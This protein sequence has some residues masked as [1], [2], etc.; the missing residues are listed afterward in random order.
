MTVNLKDILE[1]LGWDDGFQIPIANDENKELEQELAR[2]TLRK[3]KAKALFD[4]VGGRLEALKE[5]FKYVGQENE[6]TQRLISAHK[7]QYDAVQNQY[8]LFKAEDEN[9]RMSIKKI[10]KQLSD[11]ERME[12][13]KKADL[14][15]SIAKAD[16]LKAE[17]EWDTEALKGWEE[18]L[19]KRDDDNGIL[20]KFSREDEMRYNELEARRLILQSECL[21]KRET[22]K[23]IAAESHSYEMVIDRSG[24]A[25]KQQMADRESLIHQWKDAVKMLQQRDV[26]IFRAQEQIQA[27]YEA[28]AKQ[29]VVLEEEHNFLNNQKRVNHEIELEIQSINS[30]N[31]RMRRELGELAQ[32][33]LLMNNDHD[34][35]KRRIVQSAQ[36]LE[37]ARLKGKRLAERAAEM[38]RICSKFKEERQEL[39]RKQR[40][41]DEMT[42]STKERLKKL[43]QMI[44]NEERLY[45]I[46]VSDTEKI[47]CT[48]FRTERFLKE[49]K[50]I[51]KSVEIELN[52][53]MCNCHQLRKYISSLTKDLDKI[54]EVVYD[55]DF[56]IDDIERKLCGMLEEDSQEDD[57]KKDTL[58]KQI[59]KMEE[60]LADQKEVQRVLQAQVDRLQEEMR[61]LTNYIAQ[62]KEMVLTLEN[63]C[64]NFELE[65]GNGKKQIAAAKQATQEKQVEENMMLLRIDQLENEKKKEEKH[66]FSLETLRLSLDQ[67]IQERQIE[68]DTK[69]TVML[70]KRRNLDEERG[71]LR[72]DVALVRVKIEHIKK[73]YHV[74]CGNLGRDEDGNPLTVAHFRIRNAQEKFMLQQQGDDLDKKIRTA[75][76]EIT[77]LENTLK[78]VNLTN[79]S[80]RNSLASIKE[81]DEKTIEMKELEETHRVLNQHVKTVRRQVE[82]KIGKLKDTQNRLLAVQKATEERQNSVTQLEEEIEMVRRQEFE[83]TTMLKRAD[84]AIKRNL[85]KI[86]KIDITKYHRDFEIR[87]LQD[88]NKQV[89]NALYD[90]SLDFSEMAPQVHLYTGEYRIKLPAIRKPPS[91]QSS[92]STL[93]NCSSSR[94]VSTST[95]EVS[96]SVSVSTVNLS[97]GS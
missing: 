75:E 72:A 17:M 37:N 87:Q 86:G 67:A 90:L 4:N 91:S 41:V 84:F 51:A 71:R 31:C 21:T 61:S 70:A 81:D 9:T 68:I 18:A 96:T 45:T 20:K 12:E 49:E 92:L 1:K 60:T 82:D 36:H 19:R 44:D 69:Q 48:V 88:V 50:E 34:T 28:I 94:V 73:K 6:Q 39:L 64:E 65:F 14:R 74:A 27:E 79:R 33:I 26:D 62:D 53:I 42:S 80:F 7:Q 57:E 35:L 23:R 77:A 11:A 95:Y 63:R 59:R 15:K 83:K 8:H 38:E 29:E 97:F 40:D 2:L 58:N 56:R 43:E 55:M 22:V 46:Y 93:S 3:T 24:K 85:R 66:I 54:R 16:Q 10:A 25:I 32:V 13:S 5:N 47:N 78:I 52:N 30:T 76:K 89:T